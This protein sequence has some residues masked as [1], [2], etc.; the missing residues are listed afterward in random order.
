MRVF[1]LSLCVHYV[2]GTPNKSYMNW[3]APQWRHIDIPAVAK[4]KTNPKPMINSQ[5]I[6]FDICSWDIILFLR[7][8]RACA[9]L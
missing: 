6:Y 7:S 4:L 9:C 2:R 8:P 5:W 1:S 3:L